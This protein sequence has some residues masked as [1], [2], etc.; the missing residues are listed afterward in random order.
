MNPSSYRLCAIQWTV[1]IL[2]TKLKQDMKFNLRI[3]N[4]ANE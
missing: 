1:E 2:G 3:Q 4:A